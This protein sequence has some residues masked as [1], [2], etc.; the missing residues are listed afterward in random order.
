MILSRYKFIFKFYRRLH[1]MHPNN[2][3]KKQIL[4]F[5]AKNK[6]NKIKNEIYIMLYSCLTQRLLF[7]CICIKLDEFYVLKLLNSR[8]FKQF[9]CLRQVDTKPEICLHPLSQVYF[10]K[11]IFIKSGSFITFGSCSICTITNAQN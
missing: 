8:E 9:P 2:K 5:S 11:I 10:Q 4:L 1:K 7:I 3:F 6:L